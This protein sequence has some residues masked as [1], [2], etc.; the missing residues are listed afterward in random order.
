MKK[1]IV[2]P[3]FIGGLGPLTKEEEAALSRFFAEQKAKRQA[4]QQARVRRA[5]KKQAA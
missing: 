4:A 1:S 3:E 5:N 2:E